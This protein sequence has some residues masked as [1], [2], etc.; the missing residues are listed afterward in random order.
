MPE[1]VYSCGEHRQDAVHG[2]NETPTLYCQICGRVM[3]RVPQAASIVW[4]GLPPHLEHNRP[5]GA[6]LIL[7]NQNEN[8]ESYEKNLDIVRSKKGARQDEIPG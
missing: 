2:M 1:Y 6:Q 4:H 7:D 8:R 3:H 5:R